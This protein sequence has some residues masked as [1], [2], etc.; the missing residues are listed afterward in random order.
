LKP[1]LGK[2]SKIV[3]TTAT[4]F[5]P[6]HQ[7]L[8]EDDDI[9]AVV[10]VLK[11]GWLTTGPRTR[12]F[13]KAFAHYVGASNAVALSSCTAALHLALA[14]I[15][16]K[17]GD[18]VIL[19]T[20]TFSASSEVVLYFKARPV[21][22]DCQ[23][24]SFQMD[25]VA[26]ERAITARTRAI[27][28]VHFAGSPAPIDTILDIAR[29]HN[30]KVIEDAAHALPT[31]YMG[32]MV[33]SFGDVTC[34]SFYATKTLTTGEGGMVTTENPEYA[35]RIRMLSLHGISKGAENRYTAQGS[36]RYEILD[37]GYKYNMTDIQAALGLA[38][39]SK[40]DS[41]REKR[42]QLAQYYTS[43]LSTTEVFETPEVPADVQ[44]AWH[45]YVLQLR[46]EALTISRDRFIE[47]LKE[48]G[49]GTSVHFI[50]LH[51]H[52]LYRRQLGYRL[53]QFP[54]AERHF[55]RAMSLPLF[56]A[57]TKQDSEHVTEALH[58]VAREYRR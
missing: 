7:S 44:H 45:L 41:M 14:A 18:E 27:I 54:Q 1:S 32:K 33:G 50:P 48:R 9:E 17:E 43:A 28:V 53:G 6:F 16:L 49:V 57:M 26:V 36:W 12:Q 3:V 10:S 55:E 38:Q 56:P 42:E 52:P 5:L 8:I 35:D 11:S 2:G 21:L 58:D 15:G 34:F 46:L 30:L 40:C 20:M 39:L 25:P 4:K 13:E 31:R 22:V 51:T 29:R 23:P 19:P 47:E 37:V 24:D